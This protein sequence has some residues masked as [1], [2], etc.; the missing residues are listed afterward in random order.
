M[1]T[2]FIR[3]IYAIPFFLNTY[4]QIVVHPSISSFTK[5]T[6]RFM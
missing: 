1:M 2:F 6:A 4:L 5:S 3:F